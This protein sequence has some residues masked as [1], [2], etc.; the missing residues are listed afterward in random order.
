MCPQTGTATVS[1]HLDLTE[2]R[3]D[4]LGHQIYQVG[5]GPSTH[6]GIRVIEQCGERRPAG[7]E[8]YPKLGR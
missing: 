7:A 5:S 8:S 1:L 6:A 4:A 2:D 3:D